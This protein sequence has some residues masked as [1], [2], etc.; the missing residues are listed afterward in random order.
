MLN[1]SADKS[2]RSY[3]LRVLKQIY[4]ALLSEKAFRH[5]CVEHGEDFGMTAFND[6]GLIPILL[7]TPE[8]PITVQPA[9]VL[10]TS[11][12]TKTQ[13]YVAFHAVVDRVK[14]TDAHRAAMFFPIKGMSNFVIH[15][16][17]HLDITAG[18][19]MVMRFDK[20]NAVHRIEPLDS[21]IAALGVRYKGND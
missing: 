7:F 12:F 18:T 11:G 17:E 1:D 15:N 16:V 8:T 6:E 10:R 4:K 21:F 14:K 2:K 13:L 19:N 5:A 3:E 9:H 20:N